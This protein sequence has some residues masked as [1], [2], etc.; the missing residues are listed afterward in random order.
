MKLSNRYK[1]IEKDMFKISSRI[2][3]INKN[4]KVYFDR[5]KKD[6]VVFDF[7][8]STAPYIVFNAGK[9]LNFN[10]LKKAKEISRQNL[11]QVFKSVEENNK[12]IDKSK[13]NYLTKRFLGQLN[14]YIEY[15]DRKNLDNVSFD[16]FDTTKWI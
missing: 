8:F 2:K 13:Q 16:N 9:N 15:A 7:K 1:K 4:F 11:K 14:S 5:T 12:N 3:H 6:Y 10:A